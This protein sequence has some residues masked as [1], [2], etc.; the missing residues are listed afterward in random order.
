MEGF[1]FNSGQPR[2]VM[3]WYLLLVPMLLFITPLIYLG[4][5]AKRPTEI[6]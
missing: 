2:P 5:P 1:A 6:I 4:G 3:P